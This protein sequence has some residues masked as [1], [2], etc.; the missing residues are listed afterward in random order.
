MASIM[1]G[2][3]TEQPSDADRLAAAADEVEAGRGPVAVARPGRKSVG[4]LICWMTLALREPTARLA[5]SG[6]TATPR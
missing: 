2:V 5:V 6:H 4:L 3:S 1:D